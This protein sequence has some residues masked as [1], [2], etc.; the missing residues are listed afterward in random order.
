MADLKELMG[1]AQEATRKY[2][3]KEASLN[4][5]L[6]KHAEEGGFTEEE[7][8]RTVE[9]ANTRTYL[10]LRK[11]AE[12][13]YVDFDVADKNVIVDKL[14]LR[15]EAKKVV[16]PKNHSDYSKPPKKEV[17]V[18]KKAESDVPAVLVKTAE[19]FERSEAPAFEKQIVI[20][21]S[22]I[23]QGKLEYD[24]RVNKLT[25]SVR[26]LLLQGADPAAVKSLFVAVDKN[27][28]I[29]KTV[30]EKLGDEFPLVKS[31]SYYGD[32]IINREHPFIKEIEG[33]NKLASTLMDK[34]AMVDGLSDAFLKEAAI[35]KNVTPTGKKLGLA[36]L[37]ASAYG[38]GARSKPANRQLANKYAWEGIR[39]AGALK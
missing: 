1:A 12:N 9:L 20:L 6:T 13:G 32:K 30:Q 11:S 39:P 3:T 33:L 37:L 35:L 5:V 25:N 38:M 7:I 14:G 27:G 19:S 21:K 17:P 8:Q 36:M 29:W 10:E 15:K 34:A 2:L 31:A 4:D 16:C 24:G 28:G 22:E 23:G 26:Q 18:E